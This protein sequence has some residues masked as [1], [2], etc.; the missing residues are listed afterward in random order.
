MPFPL[1]NYFKDNH[2]VIGAMLKIPTKN[3]TIYF[4]KHSGKKLEDVPSEYLSWIFF[5]YDKSEYLQNAAYQILDERKI[6]P[7]KGLRK[8]RRK[9]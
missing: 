6:D 2:G 1:K 4:G 7:I 3:I 9:I 8:L 5:D